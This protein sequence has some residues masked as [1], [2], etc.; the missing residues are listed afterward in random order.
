MSGFSVHRSALLAALTSVRET[1]ARRNAIPMLAN[2]LIAADGDD[3]ICITGTDLDQQASIRIEAQQE[4]FSAVTVSAQMLFDFI[5]RLPESAEV[6]IDHDDRFATVTATNTR[7]RIRLG[8]L[9]AEDFPL[10]SPVDGM[11]EL[12]LEPSALQYALSSVEFA[13]S[14]E[15]VRYYLNGV[16]IAQAGKVLHFVATDGHRLAKVA[17]PSPKGTPKNLPGV[18]LPHKAVRLVLRML[19]ARAEDDAFSI[20]YSESRLTFRCG[21]VTLETKLV[22]GTF[23]D[24]ERVIPKD[25]AASYTVTGATLAD[26]VGRVALEN[27]VEGADKVGKACAVHFTF[28]SGNLALLT[29]NS[30]GE[31]AGDEI[32]V[33]GDKDTE[34]AF[35]G[36][37][38]TDMLAAIG[39]P[40]AIWSLGDASTPALVEPEG[41]DDTQLV[42]MP[43]RL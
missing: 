41:R 22:D 14:H 27:R 33:E 40:R 11:A 35:T 21:D 36:K 3:R 26:A 15:E 19:A 5:K 6:K 13:I 10:L 43:R 37:Y 2:V 42:L 20:G 18:I 29:R 17:T 7:A 23:P 30:D 25:N 1:V 9:P 28:S 31:E 16:Y 39:T 4:D 34:I 8:V 24:Y 38:V 32:E 12:A